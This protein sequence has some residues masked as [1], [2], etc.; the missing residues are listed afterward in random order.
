MWTHLVWRWMEVALKNVIRMLLAGQRG[1]DQ[2]LQNFI[3]I[4]P[5]ISWDYLVSS[6][7]ESN[8]RCSKESVERQSVWRQNTQ[9]VDVS[10]ITALSLLMRTQCCVGWPPPPSQRTWNPAKK[11]RDWAMTDVQRRGGTERG[12]IQEEPVLQSGSRLPRVQ[13]SS[14]H[15]CPMGTGRRS[16]LCLW[17]L[18]SKSRSTACWCGQLASHRLFPWAAKHSEMQMVWE[19]WNDLLYTESNYGLHVK[20]KFR[21]QARPGMSELRSLLRLFTHPGELER[22]YSNTK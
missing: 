1:G 11:E 18:P 12:D 21:I 15:P 10:H 2:S 17:R 20:P 14:S 22:N 6:K 3:H 13:L 19:K 8:W 9:M 16:C 4:Q 5:V 7:R